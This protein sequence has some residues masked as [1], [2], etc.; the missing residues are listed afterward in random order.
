M[1]AAIIFFIG[2]IVIKAH[3]Y[4]LGTHARLT[5][6]AYEQSVLGNSQTG[7]LLLKDLGVEPK[8]NA[9]GD[10]YYDIFGAN[11]R[12]R[13]VTDTFELKYMPADAK[14]LSISGW[15]MRGAIR[16]DDVIWPFG[17]NP[18]DD[19]YGNI[20][21]V[22]NHFYDPIHD[23]PLNVLGRKPGEA[24][25]N[26]PLVGC[27]PNDPAPK[28]AIGSGDVFNNPNTPEE[29]R[30]NHFTVFDARVAEYRALTWSRAWANHSIRTLFR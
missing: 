22:F 24:L 23:Q 30:R 1:L 12:E 29:G 11:V 9:F 28:W 14:P 21:R 19:P 25:C 17:S 20:F 6:R 4:E 15:L 3:A 8:D 18:Q 26:V 5:Q 27:Q 7:L 13:G 2:I 10:R 16:E